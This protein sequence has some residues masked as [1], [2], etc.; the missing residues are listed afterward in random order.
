MPANTTARRS[1]VVA[2]ADRESSVSVI[3]VRTNTEASQV[4][5]EVEVLGK[6]N[7][8]GMGKDVVAA[9]KHAKQDFEGKVTTPKGSSGNK[10]GMF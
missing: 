10:I 9:V 3:E 6:N 8:V 7:C 4:F 2:G 1:L 5:K